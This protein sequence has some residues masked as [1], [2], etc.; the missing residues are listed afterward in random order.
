MWKRIVF[1]S[2]II[3]GIQGQLWAQKDP[4]AKVV[5]DQVSERYQS[6]DGLKATFE[7]YYYN[8]IDGASQSSEGVV[9]VKG[10]QYKLVL[11]DQEIYNNGETVWTFIKSG[12]YREVTINTASNDAEEL[13]PSSIYN[14]YKEGYD[15]SLS[16]EA[17]KNGRA[18]QEIVLTAESAKAQF[19][20][21]RLFV[22]KANKDLIAWEVAD[23][24]GGIFKYEFKSVN[25]E[26]VLDRAFFTFDPK[27]HPGIEVIDLR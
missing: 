4:K 26:V 8:D 5:L 25:T 20:R 11:P 1:I 13:T 14:L 22:D 3:V 21:I 15:Y 27:Q 18:L 9:A 23:G 2:L 19:K 16:G 10:N 12:G 24:D 7:Y 17:V 6:L